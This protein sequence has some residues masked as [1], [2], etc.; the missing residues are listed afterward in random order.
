MS[1][2][3]KIQL[4]GFALFCTI[5]ASTGQNFEIPEGKFEIYWEKSF[6][7]KCRKASSELP[8]KIDAPESNCIIRM[9]YGNLFGHVAVP[10]ILDGDTALLGYVNVRY[11]DYSGEIIRQRYTWFDFKAVG[12]FEYRDYWVI[13]YSYPLA[14]PNI[15]QCYTVN[16]Y[17]KDGKRIDRLPFFKWECNFMSVMDISWFEMT[18]YIDEEFEI[19]VQKRSSW[20]DV[21]TGVYIGETLE[22]KKKQHYSVYHINENGKFELVDKEPKYIVDDR[23]NWKCNQ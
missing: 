21:N 16:T 23:N 3:R 10:F 20:D 8:Y 14:D 19:T 13:V 6:L 7:D 2:L 4:I 22:E 1:R 9:K 5:S 18:G 17:T 11:D 12:F 15:Y